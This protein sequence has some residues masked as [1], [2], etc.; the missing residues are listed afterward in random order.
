MAR[1][2]LALVQRA[3]G[4]PRRTSSALIDALPPSWAVAVR[5]GAHARRARGRAR[6][7]PPSASPRAPRPPRRRLGLPLADRARPARPRGDPARA[8]A[9]PPAAAA[10][11]LASAAGADARRSRRPARRRSPGRALA[12][13]GD[14][15]DGDR[16]CC[17][18]AERDFDARGVDRDRDH[19]RRELRRLG[20]RAEPRGP[21]APGDSGLASLSTPRARGRRPGHRPQDQ[22]RDRR[23]ALPEREDGRVAPAQHLR[24]AR[25]V[26]ARRVA[27]AVE[28]S[29]RV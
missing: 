1:V 16:A 10:L 8:A 15:A 13:A 11:A 9:T 3:L 22:P 12:A 24:Q 21:S 25:R 29:G 14:R 26:V 6:S 28:R 27:R 7:R 4:E 5:R 23:R 2:R 18:R 19:A 20:A 17:A